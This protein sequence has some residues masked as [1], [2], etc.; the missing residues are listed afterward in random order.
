[1]APVMD[2]DGCPISQISVDVRVAG[3][4]GVAGGSESSLLSD[5]SSMCRCFPLLVVISLHRNKNAE[6][7]HTLLTVRPYQNYNLILFHT[8]YGSI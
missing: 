6:H 1:L 7:R 3:L 8:L 5:G 4:V 2:A